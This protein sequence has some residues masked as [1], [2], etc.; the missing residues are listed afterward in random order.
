MSTLE[1]LATFDWITTVIGVVKCA[2]GYRPISVYQSEH[3]PA[4]YEKTLRKRGIK[5][6]KG[7]IVPGKGFVILV[8]ANDVAKARRILANV[9]ADLA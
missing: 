2:A 5:T 1:T 8:P 4:F 3:P 9:G 6:G 7:G